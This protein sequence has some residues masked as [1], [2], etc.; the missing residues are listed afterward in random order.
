MV[1]V[2]RGELSRARRSMDQ[3]LTKHPDDLDALTA[4]ADGLLHAREYHLA[5][6]QYEKLATK[7]PRNVAVANNLA[8]AYDSIDDPRAIAAGKQAY[9]LAPGEPPVIDTYGYMLYRK[10]DTKKG[11]ELVQQAFKLRP[12]DP[13]IAYHMAKLLKDRQDL[14]AARNLLKKIIDSKIQFD[15]EKEAKALYAQV[16]GG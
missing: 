13:S 14:V 10:G 5:A 12:Y 8:W 4:L 11:A 3:W 15:E 7:M 6:E 16:G 9:L 2:K 1:G